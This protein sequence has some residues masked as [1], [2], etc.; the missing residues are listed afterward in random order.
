M[1]SQ[2]LPKIILLVVCLAFSAFFSGS[3]TALTSLSKIRIRGMVDEGA[4]NAK[5][6]EKVTDNS[7]KLLSAILI[8]NN[9]VNIGASS[10]ATVVATDIF[11]SSGAGIAT[12][13]MTVLVLIFG[14]I[15]PKSYARDNS[16]SVAKA[17]AKP[18]SFCMFVLTPFIFVLNIITGF[19]FK[20]LGSN[21]MKHL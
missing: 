3:E 4:K 8:G 17:C 7:S 6:I 9:I 18:I 5:V 11:G 13:V 21:R 2:Y 14:E 12:G 15:T 16:E 20:L 10:I 1:D 19:L